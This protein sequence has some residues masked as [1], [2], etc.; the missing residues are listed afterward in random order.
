[1]TFSSQDPRAITLYSRRGMSVAWVLL[2]LRGDPVA[3]SPPPG[4]AVDTVPA[5]AAA[6]LEHSITGLDR[7]AAYGFWAN[8]P[9]AATVVVVNASG[10]E[11]A[12]GAVGGGGDEYG[13]SHLVS[14]SASEAADATTAVLA[15][16]TGT[17]RVCLPATHPAVQPLIA[18]GFIIADFDLFM[19]TGPDEPAPLAALSPALY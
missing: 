10:R 6:V 14:R 12:A 15:Q 19:T 4:W 1:M 17:A 9:R 16:L 7:T 2:Y 11:V 18:Q 8:R 5:P 3:L 13:I